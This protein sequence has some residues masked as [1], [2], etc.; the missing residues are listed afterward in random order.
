MANYPALNEI[1]VNNTDEIARFSLQ[2]IDNTIDH[3]D[4]LRIVYKRK[5]GSLLH[6]SKKFRFGRSKKM[7]LV[8]GGTNT[9]EFIHE[10]SPFVIK[11]TDELRSI[12][13]MKHTRSEIKV[14]IFDE[15]RRLEEEN[16]T[17]I[18]YIKKLVAKLD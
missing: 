16:Q 7:Q 17:R 12:V 8:D 11:V 1:G 4:I 18:A 9:R 3:V 14:I 2:T 15:I 5:K 10:I 6:T 13:N